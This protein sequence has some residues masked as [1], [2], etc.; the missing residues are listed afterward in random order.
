MF[1]GIMAAQTVTEVTGAAVQPAA[2]IV[3]L[4]CLHDYLPGVGVVGFNRILGAPLVA[5]TCE[6]VA[7]GIRTTLVWRV[8]LVRML[9]V[10]RMAGAVLVGMSEGYLVNSSRIFSW[11]S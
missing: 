1:N 11:A 6:F 2:S 4:P 5:I 10:G 7:W 8:K 9:G 3:R